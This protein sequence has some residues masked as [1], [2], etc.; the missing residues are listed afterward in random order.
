MTLISSS[1]LDDLHTQSL[2][3]LRLIPD[4][5]VPGYGWIAGATDTSPWI[6]I[7]L[8]EQ[9]SIT[10]VIIQGCGDQDSWVTQFCVSFKDYTEE[11]G[12]TFYGGSSL[13]NCKVTKIVHLL[14]DDVL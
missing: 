6:Q 13:A 4:I 1:N 11:N 9:Y 2:I 5:G 10:A 7:A 12:M 3:P 14:T 8:D